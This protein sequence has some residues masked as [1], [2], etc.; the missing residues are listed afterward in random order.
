MTWSKRLKKSVL[1]VLLV[2]CIT[3]AF[4]A[5]ILALTGNW[6]I[7]PNFQIGPYWNIGGSP[8]LVTYDYITFYLNT[9]GYLQVNGSTTGNGTMTG[10]TTS[11][12]LNLTAL[13]STYYVFANFTYGVTTNTTN[14]H[15]YTVAG[16]QTVWT[17]FNQLTGDIT[18]EMDVAG[19]IFY[20][21]SV[22]T[23][24][25]TTT[26]YGQGTVLA[27][28]GVAPLHYSFEAFNW[29]TG[30]TGSNPY[31]YTVT[32]DETIW[33]NFTADSYT[34]T[35]I[36]NTGG[37][38]VLNGSITSNNTAIGYGWGTTL[39]LTAI[40]SGANYVFVNWTISGTVYLTNP[41][42][43]TVTGAVTVYLYFRI[44]SVSVTINFYQLTGGLIWVNGTNAYANGTALTF[45]PGSLLNLTAQPQTLWEFSYFQSE[46]GVV[47]LNP[48]W[49]LVPDH[50]DIVWVYFI[51]TQF[52]ITV[53]L[54]GGGTCQVNG[55]VVASGDNAILNVGDTLV[56]QA[57]AQ[58]LYYFS[59]FTSII[60]ATST[61]PYS[62]TVS[63]NDTILVTFEPFYM[64]P[65]LVTMFFLNGT[66]TTNYVLGNEL[67]E[68]KGTT[69]SYMQLNA[70]SDAI[71]Y[72]GYRV[73]IVHYDGNVTELTSGIPVGIVYR[74][75]NAE[76]FQN[77]S[78]A[79][80]DYPLE[81]NIDA[82]QVDLYMRVTSGAWIKQAIFITDML[83]DTYLH[84]GN[85]VFSTYT[86]RST[87]GLA[88][89]GYAYFGDATHA[90]GIYGLDLSIADIYDDMGSKLKTGDFLGFILAPYINLVGN[91]FYGLLFLLI[92]VPLYRR[93][94]S[95][96]PILLILLIGGGIGG[97]VGFLIPQAASGIAWI[98]FAIGLAGLIYKVI[99]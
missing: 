80:P 6:D 42:Y 58:D 76:G 46:Y 96:T 97:F 62:Y 5:R 7:N 61:N 2:V 39:N 95:F 71:V 57:Y 11:D 70:V 4:T 77:A 72:W 38:F 87:V 48:Y 14:P 19:G 52:N 82:I 84:A 24:N 83:H 74:T 75:F 85:W 68:T 21:D 35:F 8:P 28:I 10:Y 50:N 13:P 79:C 94:Q 18:F 92:C 32:G 55:T 86:K 22:N 78:W 99:R 16:N 23:A 65:A 56:F 9:G 30:Y 73:Y 40:P 60:I 64:N 43:Y 93:Y 15:F 3:F 45:N 91:L 12:T 47:T 54:T 17:Y 27:L 36:Y 41:Y 37:D 66:H 53:T 88:M 34:V 31:S 90:S 44:V 69:L 25:D 49:Y 1:T 20:V 51:E 89:S 59:S 33:L 29:S 67:N 81:A 98:F 26:T 63:I